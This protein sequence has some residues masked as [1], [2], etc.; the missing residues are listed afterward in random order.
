MISSWLSCDFF[1]ASRLNDNLSRS[2][3]GAGH[4]FQPIYHSPGFN[5]REL[6]KFPFLKLAFCKGYYLVFVLVIGL[7]NQLRWVKLIKIFFPYIGIFVVSLV[8]EYIIQVLVGLAFYIR[9][10]FYLIS[11]YIFLKQR[12]VGLVHS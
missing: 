12:A 5:F 7:L 6:S 8:E 10:H 2:P 9:K 1:L 11:S 3:L 4:L